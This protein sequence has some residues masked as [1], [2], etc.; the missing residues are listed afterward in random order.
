MKRLKSKH[1]ERLKQDS[2]K[3]VKLSTYSYRKIVDIS[4]MCVGMY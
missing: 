3:N 4:N 1:D 2:L